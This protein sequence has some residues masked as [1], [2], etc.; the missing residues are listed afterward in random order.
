MIGVIRGE[1]SLDLNEIF[2]TNDL[3]Q[4]W[5][6]EKVFSS[7]KVY[8]QVMCLWINEYEVRPRPSDFEEVF[9]KTGL[10]TNKER[11][12]VWI[13]LHEKVKHISQA[14]ALRKLIAIDEFRRRFEIWG[15]ID[16]R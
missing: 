14:E 15:R 13:R 12:F 10:I 9:F 11:A 7:N 2:V 6:F 4:K 5:E 8:K 1:T 3:V 16:V